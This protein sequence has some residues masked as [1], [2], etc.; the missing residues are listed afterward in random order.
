MKTK[1]KK[2]LV[3]VSDDDLAH[4]LVDIAERLEL[5]VS[6]IARLL[7]EAG[8]KSVKDNGGLLYTRTTREIPADLLEGVK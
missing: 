1:F 6:R 8:L 4:R 5:P 2:L 3:L 7:I